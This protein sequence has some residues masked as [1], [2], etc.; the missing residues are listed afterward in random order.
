MKSM[1]KLF[2][3]LVACAAMLGTAG[4]ASAGGASDDCDTGFNYRM[5]RT[6]YA[7]GSS[8]VRSA[9]LSTDSDPLSVDEFVETVEDIILGAIPGASGSEF[10]QCR[11]E[12]FIDGAVA[13][14]DSI[15]AEADEACSLDGQIWGEFSAQLYCSLSEEFGG[16]F[17]LG[18]LPAK[19]A[20]TTCA[21][22]FE[23]TCEDT[24]E[25]GVIDGIVDAWD[26]PIVLACPEFADEPF[27]LAFAETQ[28]NQCLFEIDE[29][30]L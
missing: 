7:G 30:E 16:L 27:E 29:D 28:A 25:T 18:L 14:L 22:A 21:I 1:T 10:L 4:V 19:P 9:W 13:R 8:I 15:L 2:V 20:V 17:P 12:G 5:Y 24:F 3:S 26:D 6:G 23:E 11:L